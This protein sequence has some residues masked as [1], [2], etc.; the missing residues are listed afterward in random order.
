MQRNNKQEQ[1]TALIL[2]LM[3]MISVSGLVTVGT[4]TLLAHRTKVDTEYIR[5]GQAVG[6]ARSGLV[7]ATGWFV[8]QTTQPVIGFDPKLDTSAV[9]PVLETD[10]PEIGIVREF[11]IS[12]Q[13][14][15]RYEVWK[16]WDSDPNTSRLAFRKD[17]QV[18]DLSH[19]VGLTSGGSWRLQSTGYVFQRRD[20]AAGFAT[21]PN[22]II[23]SEV[24]AADIRRMQLSPPGQ[25]AIN[26]GRGQ[27]VTVNTQ[28]RLFGGGVGAGV[29]YPQGTGTPNSGPPGS[30]RISGTPALAPTTSTYD[31]SLE[32]VFGVGRSELMIMADNVVTDMSQFPVPVPK[33]SITVVDRP[34]VTFDNTTPL[35]STAAIVYID[36]NVTLLPGNQSVF[37]GLLYV[38]GSLTIREPCE[39]KGT[40]IVTGNL[41]VQG[42]SD[43]ADVYF[44]DDA[45]N[46]LRLNIGNYRFSSAIKKVRF[47]E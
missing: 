44:D 10:D 43:F 30:G 16:Q 13:I 34:S 32:A 15:G 6:L 33:Y 26:I 4:M 28:G 14:W 36:G 25:A 3:V 5:Y 1:G 20:P 7:E 37:T 8:K 31:D 18:E 17:N 22:R 29:Y 2:S 41:T 45:L 47:V 24:L 35:N 23:T 39:I 38:N 21:Y 9:P 12:G 40:I 42:S 46:D 19:A 27:N 11:P